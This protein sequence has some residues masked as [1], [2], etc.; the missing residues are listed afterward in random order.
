LAA[1]L[2]LCLVIPRHVHT[3][4]VIAQQYLNILLIIIA[5]LWNRAGHYIFVLWFLSI[6]FSLACYQPSQIGCLPY[7]HTWC[8]L[9]ANLWCRFETCGTRLAENTGRKKS[10]KI[11]HLGTITQ[12]CRAISSQL[13]HVSTIGKIVKEQYLLHMSLQYGELRRTSGWDQFGSLGHP[14]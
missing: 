6:F 14:S 3:T 13:R 7:F 4:A 2:A 1:P 12:L 5:A 8:G 11:R 10:P 9:S